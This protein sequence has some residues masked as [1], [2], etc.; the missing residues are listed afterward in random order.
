MQGFLLPRVCGEGGSTIIALS[1]GRDATV[2]AA[3]RYDAQG[4]PFHLSSGLFPHCLRVSPNDATNLLRAVARPLDSPLPATPA[5][6]NATGR[7]ARCTSAVPPEGRGLHLR[8][9][10]RMVSKSPEVEPLI[11][12]HLRRSDATSG[13]L[14]DKPMTATGSAGCLADGAA[15]PYR[16]NDRA[17]V[18]QKTALFAGGGRFGIAA[19]GVSS[20]AGNSAPCMR[21]WLFLYSCIPVEARDKSRAGLCEDALCT[22]AT[23]IDRLFR[24]CLR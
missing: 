21:R 18:E 16:Q 24:D 8:L 15:P 1:A 3:G 17:N 14:A 12:G 4:M 2:V 22:P 6:E 20:G 7:V 5:T 11:S 10:G 19:L 13:R 23:R 9:L